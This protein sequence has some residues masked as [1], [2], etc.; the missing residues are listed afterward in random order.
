[1]DSIDS[2]VACFEANEQSLGL[3]KDCVGILQDILV[4]DYGDLHTPVIIFSYIW[5]KMADNHNNNIYIWDPDGFLTVNFRHNL[6]R[7]VDLYVFPGQCIQ[8]FFPDDDLRPRG[9]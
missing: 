6:P 3:N 1:M 7:S 4:L 8:V 5:K 2:S 9:S